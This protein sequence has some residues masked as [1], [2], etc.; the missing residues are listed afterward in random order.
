[1]PSGFQDNR[2]A[3][4]P[5]ECHIAPYLRIAPIKWPVG[6]PFESCGF[7]IIF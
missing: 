6:L 2:L 1:M 5:L 7:R 3:L 4:L